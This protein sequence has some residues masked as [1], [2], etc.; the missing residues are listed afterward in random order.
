MLKMIVNGVT[1]RAKGLWG[2]V[3]G[4]FYQKPKVLDTKSSLHLILDKKCSVARFGDGEFNIIR[5]GKLG[6]QE[7][8]N[9]LAD[10]L[11]EVLRERV[12]GLEIGIPDVF[13]DL[14]EYTN[15]SAR[16]W[17]A[18]LGM[19]RGE[20]VQLIDLDR[21]Y[22]NTNMT[23]FWTGYKEKNGVKEI[24]EIYK[25]I[26]KG[27]NIVF[28]EGELTRMG[29]GNDLFSSAASIKRILCP[30]KNA[31]D[32]YGEIL[33]TILEFRMSKDTLFILALG[34]TA[35]VLA[36]DLAKNGYQAL[37]LGHLD[38]QYEYSLRNAT[39][40][41]A[42]EGKYVNEN[43]AGREVSDSIVDDTYRNSVIARIVN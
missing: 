28:V 30:A 19:H 18:Y 35:T 15:K 16:F 12:D 39:D 37:D 33:S 43:I 14:S 2:S 25:E 40:K 29:V 13:E 26:W 6:F 31:W 34:P 11:N 27:R 42:I 5:G 10:K 20:M 1:Y 24:V 22:L 36:Y 4:I 3:N 9:S 41:M 8:N 17:K 21:A 23:R 7:A 32:R 38:V